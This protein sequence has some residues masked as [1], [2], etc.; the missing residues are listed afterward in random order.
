MYKKCKALGGGKYVGMA[1]E[2]TFI[3]VRLVNKYLYLVKLYVI[4]GNI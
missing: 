2:N 1:N 4:I 3:L